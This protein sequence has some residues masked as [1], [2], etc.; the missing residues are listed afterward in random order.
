V[1]RWVGAGLRDRAAGGSKGPSME[2][3][4]RALALHNSFG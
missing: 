2:V 3:S 1:G 4:I